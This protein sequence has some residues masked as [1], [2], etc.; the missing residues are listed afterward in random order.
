M[1]SQIHKRRTGKSLC[2]TEQAVV[3]EQ[4]YEERDDATHLLHDP[5]KPRNHAFRRRTRYSLDLDSIA[6]TH[7]VSTKRP[8]DDWHHNMVN[9]LF[10]R[11]FPQ[12]ASYGHKPELEPATNQIPPPTREQQQFASASPDTSSPCSD[13]TAC[14]AL[15]DASLSPSD[16][17]KDLAADATFDCTYSVH[18]FGDGGFSFG[19][20]M[21]SFGDDELSDTIAPMFLS[22]GWPT[23]SIA[24]AADFDAPMQ[25][26]T[27]AIQWPMSMPYKNKKI[28]R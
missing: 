8:T 11:A 25:D 6:T 5:L 10:A 13:F 18:S 1:A 28:Y 3:S 21:F 14:G 23:G 16:P 22:K 15:T 24:A 9:T 26:A 19:D 20:E 4:M 2:I 27:D 17:A 7:E 12:I